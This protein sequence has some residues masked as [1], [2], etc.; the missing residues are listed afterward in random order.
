M[1]VAVIGTGTMGGMHARLLA[2]L[3]EVGEVLLVDA[4]DALA[5]SL[6]REIGGRALSHDEA[7][8]SADAVVIATPAPFHAATVEAAAAAGIPALCEKPLTDDLASSAALVDLV[9]RT[10]AY[11]EM[12]FQRRHDAAFAEA[13][14][15][16][17][18]GSSGRIHLLRLTAFDPRGPERPAGA[19]EVTEAAP[20]FLHSSVHDFDLARWLTGSEVVEV[21][22][23]G[24]H[25]DG[26]FAEDPRDIETAAVSLR[27]ANGALATLD[28]TWLHPGGYDVRAEIVA[29]RAHL[30]MGLSSRTPAEHLDWPDAGSAPWEGYLERFADA[31][32]AEL[33]AFMAAARGDRAPASSAH[34]GLEALR[35][36][37]AATRSHVERRPVS[38][39]DVS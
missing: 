36:A 14:R 38:L 30:T 8:A 39:A 25:R 6:A 33:I 32:R 5:A 27:M 24:T 26:R 22:A 1:R 12:G 9:E 23:T 17:L 11:V 31:Y 28:A 19:W 37:V 29:D 10:G 20:V 21:T 13:R 2:G 35:V 18:D 4:D 7:I 16:I 3:P 34:D 15:R